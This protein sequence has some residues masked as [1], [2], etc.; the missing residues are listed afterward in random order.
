MEKT[1][2][3]SGVRPTGLLHIGHLEGMLK[4]TA[5]LQD[6][7]ECYPFIADWHALTDVTD[8]SHLPE[9]TLQVAIDWLSAGIDPEKSTLFVQ[10][11]VPEHAELSTLL[12]MV[13]PVSWLE[14]CPTY[15]DKIQDLDQREGP[16]TGLLEYPVLMTADV[17]IYKAEVVPV[18]GDQVPHLEI[19]REIVRRFNHL[20][21][22]V[23]PEPQPLLTEI[24]AL[25]G[26][27]G[28]KMSKSY[29]NTIDLADPPETA[30]KKVM[31]MVTDPA[32][33]RRT[34]PGNPDVCP[35]F[36][37]HNVYNPDEVPQIDRDCRSAA[38]G[39]VDCK[40]NLSQK[41]I[42]TLTPFYE[43]RAEWASKPD[44]VREVLADGQSRAE[45]VA[46]ETMADV[47][48]AMNLA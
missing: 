15:K 37:Y 23:F 7:Y 12:T 44:R 40:R 2:L 26:L 24:A 42:T 27:D 6:K 1:R 45:K 13:T 20:F 10:S 34:D 47:R 14:R 43:K 29:N 38:I 25:P 28:R 48:S 22:K 39:C 32:R 30:Q 36:A 18:G 11:H 17:I 4:N 46:Q 33:V 41:L 8:T 3:V 35:V 21:G 19:S 5:S 16:S 9:Y 31:Q